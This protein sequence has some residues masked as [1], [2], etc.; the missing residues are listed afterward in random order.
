ML[1]E[2]WTRIC[3]NLENEIGSS[4]YKSWIDPLKLCDVE[5]S[6]AKFIAPTVFMGNWV[7]RNYGQKIHEGFKKEGIIID[8]LI[9]N[10]IEVDLAKE[11]KP[12]VL[13]AFIAPVT[14]DNQSLEIL[15]S[16]DD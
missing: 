16:M 12:S 4:A 15:G 10:V 13:K 7:Q 1:E 14:I 11:K 9:F 6:I 5:G 8:R 2:Q 3:L